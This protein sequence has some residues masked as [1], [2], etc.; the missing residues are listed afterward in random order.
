MGE[1]KHP[2][3]TREL[4]WVGQREWELETGGMG[5]RWESRELIWCQAGVVRICRH[6]RSVDMVWRVYWMSSSACFHFLS[7]D[8][9]QRVSMSFSEEAAVWGKRSDEIAS[10]EEEWMDIKYDWRAAQKALMRLLVV[11]QNEI[12][13]WNFVTLMLAYWLHICLIQGWSPSD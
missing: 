7:G 8:Q 11:M 5:F 4:L 1:E 12:Y 9:G 13:R 2:G 10:R 3:R 6:W